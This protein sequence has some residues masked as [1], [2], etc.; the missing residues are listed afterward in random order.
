MNLKKAHASKRGLTEQESSLLKRRTELELGVK[1]LQDK[2]T[3]AIGS[4][5]E[6]AK[7]LKQ[8]HK[9]IKD[10]TDNLGQLLNII[11]HVIIIE[12]A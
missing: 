11:K 8:L 12:S 7:E 5:D 3:G 4:K 6:A 1:D 10:A 9:K 2:I